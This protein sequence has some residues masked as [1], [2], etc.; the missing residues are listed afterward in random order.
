MPP[1]HGGPPSLRVL[2]LHP[3][4]VVPQYQS[5][6]AAGLDLA[7]CLPAGSLILRPHQILKVPTGIAI[8]IPD[9]FEGQVR[10]RSGLSSKHGVAPVNSPGTI[11]CDYR[12][13]VL[14]PLINHGSEAFAIAHG[15]RIAQLV[16]A[17]VARVAVVEVHTLDETARG[18][19]GF[20]S[21]GPA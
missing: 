12:G 17:P 21:T 14:V 4:A 10:A 8:A 19:G 3:D 9:G 11:D 20:G 1:M 2:R 13:E 18:R 6:G 7:A 16:I 5:A 15:L